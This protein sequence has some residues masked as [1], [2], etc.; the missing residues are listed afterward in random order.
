MENLLRKMLMRKS[1]WTFC[2]LTGRVGIG[3]IVFSLTGHLAQALQ[4]PRL[5][6]WYGLYFSRSWTARESSTRSYITRCVAKSIMQIASK[7]TDKVIRS[8]QL[9]FTEGLVA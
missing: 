2:K 3:L 5:S 4:K 6:H 1:Q 8:Q 7:T 9:R